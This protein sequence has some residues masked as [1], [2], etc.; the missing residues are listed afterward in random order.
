MELSEKRILVTGGAGFVGSHLAERL[1]ADNDVVVADN[2]TNG[3]ASWVPDEATL[4]EGDLTDPEFVA[5][6][7]TGDVDVVFHFA[8]DKNAAADDVEQYRTNN[9][10][11]E[12]VLPNG[13]TKSASKISRLRRL[14]PYTASGAAADT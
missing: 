10:M 14:R 6:A 7:I 1:V 11:T 2:L 4:V 8:A 12:N 3:D 13:W 9:R 5:E